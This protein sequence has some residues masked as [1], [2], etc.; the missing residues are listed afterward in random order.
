MF[1]VFWEVRL[2]SKSL[3]FETLKRIEALDP[4]TQCHISEYRDTQLHLYENLTSSLFIP[5]ILLCA[6]HKYLVL[7]CVNIHKN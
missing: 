5:A 7:L 4:A 3:N 6:L 2:R 1:P